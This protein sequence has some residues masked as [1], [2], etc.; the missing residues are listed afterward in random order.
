[1]VLKKHILVELVPLQVFL[2]NKN[3]M[4]LLVGFY[5]WLY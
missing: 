4:L 2:K 5:V 1:M 3:L